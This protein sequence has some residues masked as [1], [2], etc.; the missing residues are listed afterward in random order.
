MKKLMILFAYFYRCVA[1]LGLLSL[2]AVSFEVFAGE[3][4]SQHALSQVR[5]K[6][7]QLFK[8]EQYSR[9]DALLTD[10]IAR[11]EMD[12]YPGAATAPNAPRYYWLMSDLMA[13]Q[14][15]VGHYSRCL[16]KGQGML[17]GWMSP[18]GDMQDQHVYHA[19]V[20]NNEVCRREFAIQH[21]LSQMHTEPCPDQTFQGIL[22]SQHDQNHYLCLSNQK[23]KEVKNIDA[24][25]L[26]YVFFNLL[27]VSSNKRQISRLD[28][29]QGGL[30]HMDYCG[31]AP[32]ASGIVDHQLQVYLK[33]SLYYC[34]PGN[35]AFFYRGVFRFRNSQLQLI[36]EAMV[37]LH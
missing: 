35:A 27:R 30:S 25:E 3:Q 11:C 18:L 21:K 20:Y 16:A 4:C 22:L 36:D 31:L 28:I 8:L 12:L 9:A 7:H 29:T 1:L 2:A 32:V 26:S 17:Y 14:I 6:A 24:N 34:H 10:F 15:K 37:G 13:A 33:G 5:V 23:N 19:I